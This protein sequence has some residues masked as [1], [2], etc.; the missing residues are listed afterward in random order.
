MVWE[1]ESIPNGIG[2]PIWRGW[3]GL[4]ERRVAHCNV[5]GRRGLVKCS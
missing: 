4:E 5:H 3:P 1:E 2:V